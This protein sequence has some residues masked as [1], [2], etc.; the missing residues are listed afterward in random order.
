VALGAPVV[1]CR[2][3]AVAVDRP[4]ENSNFFDL[5]KINSN[6]FDLIRSKDGL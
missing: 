1:V 3:W 6:G 2:G 4:E 5:F